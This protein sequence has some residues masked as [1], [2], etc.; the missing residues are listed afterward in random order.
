[1]VQL[2]E[3][4][5]SSLKTSR[6]LL[7]LLFSGNP[8]KQE[9]VIRRERQAMEAGSRI[10]TVQLSQEY[11]MAMP[12]ERTDITTPRRSKSS[13]KKVATAATTRLST[14]HFDNNPVNEK[15]T[16]KF[17]SKILNDQAS[18]Q[19]QPLI[20]IQAQK[21]MLK[22]PSNC[23]DTK[24][25]LEKVL[26][27][28]T[29]D[30]KLEDI[31]KTAKDIMKT[32][33]YNR[34]R[35]QK[36]DEPNTL[37]GEN[38]KEKD[39]YDFFV[40]LIETTFKVY[41][42]QTDFKNE[43][44]RS[45]NV[46]EIDEQVA[47][48]LNVKKNLEKSQPH[49][50][51][52]TPEQYFNVMDNGIYTWNDQQIQVMQK[53]PQYKNFVP[54]LATT[55]KRKKLYSRSFLHSPQ[56]SRYEHTVAERKPRK[57]R[58][59]NFRSILLDTLKEDLK[60]DKEDLEEPQNMH[61]ALKI[62]AKNKRKCRL[63]TIEKGV[64]FKKIGDDTDTECQFKRKRVISSAPEAIKHKKLKKVV[65][66]TKT[67]FEPRN[68]K[69]IIA[70][71]EIYTELD[72]LG[73]NDLTDTATVQ[74]IEVKGFDYDYN[75]TTELPDLTFKDNQYSNAYF[76]RLGQE[77]SSRYNLERASKCGVTCVETKP[78]NT[79]LDI[80]DFK[81]ST[82]IIT[83]YTR[84]DTDS[85]DDESLGLNIGSNC[86][87]LFSVHSDSISKQLTQDNI[88]FLKRYNEKKTENLEK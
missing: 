41:N 14:N 45:N 55:P 66:K 12:S 44:T 86:S 79:V 37:V 31:N 9:T 48:K 39:I 13:K 88:E 87:S 27:F 64:R 49:N 74:S 50:G 20:V 71:Y 22:T 75:M 16:L 5:N 24:E 10:G 58:F 82:D 3:V 72:E 84:F 7:L 36:L 26:P 46:M 61:E 34:S 23:S 29:K 15:Q 77:D 38:A 59:K 52:R 8:E 43:H 18:K 1:M 62:I 17:K 30:I 21:E 40:K 53:Q 57:K 42:V 73:L 2:A 70:D 78:N 6:L 83:D 33:Q 85:D 65:D 54:P 28:A 69:K 56:T 76:H 11:T 67:P 80:N 4:P 60:M 35:L 81:A 32:T 25:L 47:T 68:P 51:L 19:Y 63:Q